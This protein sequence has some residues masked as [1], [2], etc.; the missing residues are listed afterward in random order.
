ML[1]RYYLTLRPE[2]PE[3]IRMEWA[4]PLY[5]ALLEQLPDAVGVLQHD[6]QRTGLSQYVRRRPDGTLNWC[7]GLLGTAAELAF[8][9]ALEQLSFLHLRREQQTLTVL[10]R[11]TETVGS[12]EELLT[13]PQPRRR[14]L[15]F[16]TPTAFKSRGT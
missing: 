6:G 9:P 4:Y 5:A 15:H 8:C 7:V 3:T 12:V 1:T 13:L 2:Q 10:N 11:Q 16:V 14:Q